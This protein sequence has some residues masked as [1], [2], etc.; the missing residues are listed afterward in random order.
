[1]TTLTIQNLRKSYK[2]NVVVK[3][4]SLEIPKDKLKFEDMT[5]KSQ[6]LSI[7]QT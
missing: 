3:N 7:M 2:K 5:E 1:M 4:V 6:Q